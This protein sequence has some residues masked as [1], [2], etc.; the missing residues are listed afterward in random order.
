MSNDSFIEKVLRRPYFIYSFLTLFLFLG[1]MG[2]NIVNK[3]LFPDSNRPEIAVVIVNPGASAKTI[4]ATVSVPVEQEL[5]TIDKVRRVYSTTIDEVS[6]IRA[7]FEYSKDLGNASNDVAA[8]LD[9]IRSILPPDIKEPILHKI[10]AASAPIIT[11]S[12][13][14]ANG[15]IALEDIRVLAQNELKNSLLKAEGIANVDVFGGHSKEL[16]VI[17]DKKKL[18]QYGMSID[19]LIASLQKN[20]RDYAIGF[21]TNEKDR[22]LLKS[23]GKRTNVE[24]LKEIA[25]SKDI[26]LGDLANI[27]FG[28]YEN[29]ALYYGN[30][31]PAIALALQRGI[32]ADVVKSIDAAEKEIENFRAKYPNLTFEITDTQKDTIV[33]ST[34]NMFE[35]LR[36]AIIMSTI[37]VFLFLASFRQ[38]L[39]VLFLMIL[40]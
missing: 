20:N 5:Y 27:Y 25:V 6:V 23:Q 26:C 8:A 1:V 4:A 14:S 11:L 37:V 18:D 10:S 15:S 33:Q 31:K 28:H 19:M 29:S 24:A 3:K 9:K 22:Y 32:N 36:D 35:S 7:E 38:V 30:S 39:V 2:Y 17:V 34:S 40:S 12:V 16:H 13:S 21:I